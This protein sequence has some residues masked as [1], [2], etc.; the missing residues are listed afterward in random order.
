MTR[1]RSVVVVGAGAIGGFVGASLAAAGEPITLVEADPAHREAIRGNGLRVTGAADLHVR[2]IALAPSEVR[3]PLDLVLLAVKTRDTVDALVPIAPLLEPDGA[4]VS[5]QNGLEE[6]TIAEHVGAHRTIGAALTFGGHYAAPGH[7]EYGGPGS[8]YIGELDGRDTARIRGLRTLLERAHP[9][10]ISPRIFDVLWGKTA[11]AAFYS[12]TALVDADV[13]DILARREYL[14]ALGSL[15]AEVVTV[16]DA[17]GARCAPSDGFDPGAFRD[18][19]ADRITAS[20]QAQERYWQERLSRRTGVWRDLNIHHRRTEVPRILGPVL[21]RADALSVPVPRL[22]LVFERT[23]QAEN[24]APPP[25]LTFLDELSA[26]A[27]PT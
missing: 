3:P 10:T 12:A 20:W 16:A 7:V 4:V 25:G 8:L 2:P 19:D 26:P 14:P 18:G 22:T 23:R 11:L 9:T 21:A 6:Y 5:L 24:G 17:A 13:L 27:A 1:S 15:V